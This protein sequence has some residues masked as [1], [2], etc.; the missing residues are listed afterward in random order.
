VIYLPSEIIGQLEKELAARPKKP[1]A[2]YISPSTDPFPPL[3][4]VQAETARVVAALAR[5][6]IDS[7]LMTRG[8][9]RPAVLE[10]LAA[11]RER[12][13]VTVALTTLDRALQRVLEPLTGS[14]RLRLRQIRRLRRLGIQVQVALEPI[15][16]GLTDTR[17]SLAALLQALAEAGVTRVTA[18]YLFLRPRI[19]DSLGQALKP[20]GWDQAVL[21]AYGDGPILQAGKLA[22]ARYL[23][24]TRRQR[25]YAALMALASE[26]GITVGVSALANPDFRTAAQGNAPGRP[27]Q[28]L[29]P[30]F[31][32]GLSDESPLEQLGV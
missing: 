8:Y 6:G 3:S 22:P 31:T 5:H 15:I 25:G 26:L 7:W 17:E 29:L 1:R 16:P 32:Q 28:R 13:K 11:H 30:Q 4:E 20:H 19:Q 24:K 9:I 23:A 21:D 2:V 18:G 12:V 27:V 10:V 14:P